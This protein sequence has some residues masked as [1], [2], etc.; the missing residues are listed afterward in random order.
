M[1]L[2]CFLVMLNLCCC[3]FCQLN[4]WFVSR[5]DIALYIQTPPEEVFGP[6]KHIPIKSYKYLLRGISMSTVE[7][8]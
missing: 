1:F 5:L 8:P 4:S 2:W 6:G 7:R 3:F